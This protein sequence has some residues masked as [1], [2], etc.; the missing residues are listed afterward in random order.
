MVVIT[1]PAQDDDLTITAVNVDQFDAAKHKIVSAASC[2]SNA[3]APIVKILHDGLGIKHGYLVTTHAYTNDQSL[4]DAPHKSEDLRRARAA[5]ESI[6]PTSTGAAKT[7]GKLI[8]ELEGKLRGLAMRVP[9][10][11]PS[12]LNLTVEVKKGTT[13]EEVNAL[14]KQASEKQFEDV[15]GYSDLPLVS[16]DHRGSPFAG[17]FDSLLTDV[18]DETQ[19]NVVAWYDNEWGFVSQ[20]MRLIKQIAS[21]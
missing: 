20:M 4:V 11:L 8:P 9:V 21:K 7:I 10:I 16:V 3:L 5:G 12:V 19:V 18:V 14:F 2:T 17:V 6:I 15:L 1:A 13:P